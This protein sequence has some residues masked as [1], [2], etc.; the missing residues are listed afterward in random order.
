MPN[1]PTLEANVLPDAAETIPVKEGDVFRFAFNEAELAARKPYDPRHCFD[2]QL[3]AVNRGGKI[4][5]RDTYWAHWNGRTNWSDQYNE[6]NQF[7]W[8]GSDGR[9]FTEQ[10]A[11][12]KGVLEFRFNLAD[13][14]TASADVASYYDDADWFDISYQHGCYKRFVLKKGAKRSQAKMAGV[15]GEKLREARLKLEWISSQIDRL[16]EIQQKIEAG[17]LDVHIPEKL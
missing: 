8:A 13:I 7:G 11:L 17:D 15:I 14:E 5:L 10:Q 3:V 1:P 2:G 4:V 16:S 9:A 6:A 12:A